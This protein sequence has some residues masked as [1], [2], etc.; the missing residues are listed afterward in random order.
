[1]TASFQ[2][3][4][5]LP[6]SRGTTVITRPWRC[7]G[8][9]RLCDDTCCG[10]LS[11]SRR[12]SMART[13]VT[14]YRHTPVHTPFRLATSHPVLPFLS[15]SVVS[16]PAHQRLH[17]VGITHPSAPPPRR[18]Y[19][20]TSASTTSALPIPQRLHHVGITLCPVPAY[21]VLSLSF[22]SFRF[23][24]SFSFSS[25][26]MTKL[27]NL[28][29]FICHLKIGS[30]PCFAAAASRRRDRLGSLVK[31]L[32]CVNRWA[33]KQVAITSTV[34]EHST[35]RGYAIS[36]QL[37]CHYSGS[38]RCSCPASSAPANLFR[39]GREIHPQSTKRE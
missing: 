24:L 1:M 12:E 20:P 23:F 17:H 14:H 3:R 28:E 30:S 35:S 4:A 16:Q 2:G 27:N 37:L 31:W 8:R 25:N 11:E 36:C 9:S 21:H 18:H 5:T 39:P 7:V 34:W 32:A 29:S 15:H 13:T 19:P 38:N 6:S 33:P 10:T 26:E 22:F